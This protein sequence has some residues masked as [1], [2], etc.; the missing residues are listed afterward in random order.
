MYCPKGTRK[1]F[2]GHC[3][4]KTST[5]TPRCSKGTR[6]CSDEICHN[7][8]KRSTK[9]VT[10]KWKYIPPTLKVDL[11]LSKK[12]V[13]KA[14]KLEKKKKAKK[15]SPQFSPTILKE[16]EV[17]EKRLKPSTLAEFNKLNTK[18]KVEIMGMLKEYNLNKPKNR[19]GQT[20]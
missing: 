3:V 10:N 19:N 5:K 13:T 14:E 11:N 8:L 4:V 16:I 12:Y 6:K 2:N 18:A 20:I 9:S 15:A 17:H 7:S 1:C